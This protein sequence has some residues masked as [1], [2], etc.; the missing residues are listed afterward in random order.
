MK[1]KIYNSS[2][3]DKTIEI[4]LA[5][6]SL[7]ISQS[8]ITLFSMSGY[9]P[10]PSMIAKQGQAYSRGIFPDFFLYKF[11]SIFQV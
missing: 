7:Y 8:L 10:I 1:K 4:I 6:P 2:N 5:K 3:L 9:V 11:Q